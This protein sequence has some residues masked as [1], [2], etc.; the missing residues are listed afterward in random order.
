MI[1][2]YFH[3]VSLSLTYTPKTRLR[4]LSRVNYY[5]HLSD[6][7]YRTLDAT[8]HVTV[9]QLSAHVH[10][11]SHNYLYCNTGYSISSICSTTP[12]IVPATPARAI[13]TPVPQGNWD[14]PP[15]KGWHAVPVPTQRDDDP[16]EPK[17]PKDAPPSKEGWYAT[18]ATT[19]CDAET[20]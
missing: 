3:A 19:G 18:P 7:Y 13:K 5:I 8:R 9:M 2:A 1:Y 12:N 10:P 20:Q 4:H 6:F 15:A 17:G 16:L 11:S 14:V